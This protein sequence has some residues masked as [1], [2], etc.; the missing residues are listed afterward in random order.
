MLLIP[1][2]TISLLSNIESRKILEEQA[3][4]RTEAALQSAMEYIDI[5]LL[6]V[7]QLSNIIA[8]DVNIISTL[9]QTE[10]KLTASDI[11]RFS[12]LLSDIIGI[13]VINPSIYDMSVLH[14]TSEMILKTNFGGKYYP[15]IMLQDWVQQTL[16]AN[17]NSI[18]YLAN[19][20]ENNDV[21]NPNSI[22][23]LRSIDP[24][25]KER[26][27]SILIIN[28]DKQYLLNLTNKL[29]PS[30]NAHIYIYTNDNQLVA[31]TNGNQIFQTY[32]NMINVEVKS[33]YSNWKLIMSQPEGEVFQKTEQVKNYTIFIIFFSVILAIWIAWIIYTSIYSPLK[34]LAFGMKQF[35]L[36]NLDV[37]LTN[38]RYDEIGFL[39]S[40]FNEMVSVQKHLIKDHY[41]QQLR[42]SKTELQFLQSQINPHFLYNTLDSIYWTA[43]NYDANEISEMVLNLSKFFRLSLNK[44]RE[45]LPL[46]SSIEHLHFYLRVQQIRFSEQFDVEYDIHPD[47]KSIPILKLLLQ[48]LVENAIIH[49]LEKKMSGGKLKVTSY[50]NQDDLV[51]EVWDNGAGITEERLA[52][53][54]NSLYVF[55]KDREAIDEVFGLRNVVARLQLYYG[56]DAEFS[57]HSHETNGTTST[58]KIKVDKC[59]TLAGGTAV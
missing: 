34:K 32:P 27:P 47:T 19:T 40:S 8:T 22:S 18:L 16:D 54:R 57:I 6:N 42:L 20:N 14:S 37:Q 50:I 56:E 29:R 48:P 9:D 46:Q 31:S 36:G 58:I 51:L 41:E 24:Y 10:E 38:N 21:F 59:I 28:I 26:S 17:G 53:I 39:T 52:F 3:I 4:E 55:M 12:T 33:D 25:K 11:F 35:R 43:K 49:G 13:T 5:T 15:G 44:G 7:E 30:E 23:F 2:V 1:L 45:I